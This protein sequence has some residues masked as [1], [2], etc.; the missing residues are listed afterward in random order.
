MMASI[1]NFDEEPSSSTTKEEMEINET[2]S[3]LIKFL[4]VNTSIK[5]KFGYN[6]IDI[7]IL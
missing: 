1:C 7:C 6:I 4:L 3:K 5:I 2:G